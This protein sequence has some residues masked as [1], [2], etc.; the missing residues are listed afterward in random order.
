MD[1]LTDDRKHGPLK[2]SSLAW[3]RPRGLRFKAQT[4]LPGPAPSSGAALQSRCTAGLHRC[5]PFACR[6]KR[7]RGVSVCREMCFFKEMATHCSTLAREIPRTGEP[8]ELQSMALQRAAEHTGQ[9]L[10]FGLH[11][12]PYPYT[13]PPGLE[14]CWA[15]LRWT[16]TG[17]WSEEE[18]T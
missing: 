8:G 5:L 7:C 17:D 11:F 15:G 3:G 14:R 16:W 13:P 9:Y 2:H 10:H 12:I 6:G 4:Q 1:S 18:L